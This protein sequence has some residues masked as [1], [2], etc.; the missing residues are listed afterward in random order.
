LAVKSQNILDNDIK[1]LD[2]ILADEKSREDKLKAEQ[3]KV[4]KLFREKT[5]GIPRAPATDSSN[6]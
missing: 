3:A 6:F 5:I 2:Q 1:I 4:R